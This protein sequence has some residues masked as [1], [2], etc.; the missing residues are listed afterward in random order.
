MSM[1]Q[2]TRKSH[3]TFHL[4]YSLLSI[5]LFGLIASGLYA[6]APGSEEQ[7][8][9][10]DLPEMIR[11]QIIDTTQ[12]VLTPR[13]RFSDAAEPQIRHVLALYAKERRWNLPPIITPGKVAKAEAAPPQNYTLHLSAYPSLPDSLFYNVLFGGHADE[14]RGYLRLDR[15]QLGDERTKGRG[16]YNVDGVRY[17]SKTWG[18]WLQ[19][20][21]RLIFR[22][23][24]SFSVLI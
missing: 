21:G 1:S 20:K 2:R 17:I 14:T 11:A 18:G 9:A 16:D 15:K 4:S 12:I 8:K 19:H 10:E 13:A 6:Q 3:S 22:K 7:L 5:L 23:S 24:C